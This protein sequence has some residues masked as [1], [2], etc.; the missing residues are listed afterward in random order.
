VTADFRESAVEYPMALALMSASGPLQASIEI[1]KQTV[2]AARGFDAFDSGC[3]GVTP[4]SGAVC[5]AV[6]DL[7]RD[8]HSLEAHSWRRSSRGPSRG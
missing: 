3:A 1:A 7:P 6:G 8:W 5:V 4:L 2:D